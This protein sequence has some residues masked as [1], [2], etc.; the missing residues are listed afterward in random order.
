MYRFEDRRVTREKQFKDPTACCAA[1][2]GLNSLLRRLVT[3]PMVNPQRDGRC[4]G[5]D[6]VTDLVTKQNAD[7]EVGAYSVLSCCFY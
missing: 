2:S 5:T 1:C 4:D 7:L 6:L 3:R